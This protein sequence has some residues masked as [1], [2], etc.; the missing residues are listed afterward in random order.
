MSITFR[1]TKDDFIASGAF[2]TQRG[3]E[4]RR[5]FMLLLG[6]FGALAAGYML[7]PHGVLYSVLGAGAFVPLMILAARGPE[8]T[9][10]LAA[11][12]LYEQN[13]KRIE[14]LTVSWSA[15]GLTVAAPT[16]STDY[17]W[18]RFRGWA[19]NDSLIVLYLGG[20]MSVLLPKRAFPDSEML[21]DLRNRLE[22]QGVARS[23]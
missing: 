22:Q 9:R 4:R 19:E 17:G 23:V 2:K 13:R 7:R 12:K 1:L 21:E 8:L 11:G 16:G 20:K 6:G 18:D 15:E 14:D 3:G 10:R 5:V